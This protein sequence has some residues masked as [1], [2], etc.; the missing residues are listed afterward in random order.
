MVSSSVLVCLGCHSKISHTRWLTYC[1]L[2][3]LWFWRLGGP[4]SRCWMI[5]FLV[6]ALFLACRW[7][8][9][10]YILNP[11][12]ASRF[13]LQIASHWDL[14]PQYVNS[15]GTQTFSPNKYLASMCVHCSQTW[16]RVDRDHIALLS[17]PALCFG[18]FIPLDV[19]SSSPS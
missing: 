14:E 2:I 17:D 18:Q 11:V 15:R 12:T 1:K 16:L 3:F 19:V 8:L 7:L 5:L 6:R 13:Y 9:S 4:R 10:C